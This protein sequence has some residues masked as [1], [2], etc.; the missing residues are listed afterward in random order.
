VTLLVIL[1]LLGLMLERV[2]YYT[3]NDT[4][5]IEDENVVEKIQRMAGSWSRTR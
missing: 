1:A 5:V 4:G 2:I 3:L